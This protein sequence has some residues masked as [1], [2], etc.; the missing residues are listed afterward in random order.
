M[1]FWQGMNIQLLNCLY[2]NWLNM[3]ERSDAGASKLLLKKIES[4]R[5]S[6]SIILFSQPSSSNSLPK[7]FWETV[8]IQKIFINYF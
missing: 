4:K 3:S 8:A 5:F 1:L 2:I 6:K 7:K